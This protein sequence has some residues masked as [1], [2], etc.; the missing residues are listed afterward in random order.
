MR[1]SFVVLMTSLAAVAFT[2]SLAGCVVAPAE[3]A[4]G[5]DYYQ[6]GYAY[7]PYPVYAEPSVGV[8]IGFWG[9]G[10]GW[11]GHGDH[12]RGGGGWHGRGGWRH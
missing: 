5:Y 8:G 9:G 10:G 7:Y 11:H 1:K 4:Y 12:W 6:P 2:G 3:P